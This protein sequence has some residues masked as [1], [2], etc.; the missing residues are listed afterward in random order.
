M[1]L[2]KP[3][4]SYLQH[5]FEFSLKMI[6]DVHQNQY[7]LDPHHSSV[8]AWKHAASAFLHASF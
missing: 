7:M 5:T 1:R 8:S 2:L 4:Y 6:L 3:K